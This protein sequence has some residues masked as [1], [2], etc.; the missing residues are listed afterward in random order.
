ME[1]LNAVR[2]NNY[3]KVDQCL[4]QNVKLDVLIM[5]KTP[6]I[7]AA[8]KG[9]VQIMRLLISFGASIDFTNRN[10]ETALIWAAYNGQREAVNLLIENNVKLDMQDGDGETAL[11]VASKIG[12]SGIVYDLIQNGVSFISNNNG[13]SPLYVAA[14][15]SHSDVVRLLLG[16]NINIDLKNRDGKTALDIALH[17]QDKNII[18]MIV[19]KKCSE[20]E[21]PIENIVE[22]KRD[23]LIQVHNL[24]L[25]QL[26]SL[27]SRKENEFEK[28]LKGMKFHHQEIERK[29]KQIKQIEREIT[30][31]NQEYF[32]ARDIRDKLK[33]EIQSMSDNLNKIKN[34]QNTP[35]VKNESLYECPI[36]FEIP[37]HPM[38]VYQCMD[39]HIYCEICK[40][41]PNMD[42]CP[43]CRKSIKDLNI[44][45]LAFESMVAEWY[46]EMV[47]SGSV[48]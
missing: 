42:K 27:L 14:Y 30:M 38:R 44:R 45:S 33:Q 29:Q 2:E 19:N 23:L 12:H 3:D 5:D 26:K 40:D 18:K 39:G 4:R 20:T 6:F 31:H 10:R 24:E 16:T 32:T 46:E 48:V 8:S 13:E 35:R 37:L 47:K 41:K 9:Y 22:K 36:C 15:Y 43:M 25:D 7:E 21:T 11:V 28:T 34:G 1:L 17:K